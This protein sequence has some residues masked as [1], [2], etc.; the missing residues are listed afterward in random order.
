MTFSIV[1]WDALTGMTGVAVATKHLA[2]G[3]LVPHARAGVGAIATHYSDIITDKF[4]GYR[5]RNS[6]LTS[7]L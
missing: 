6:T 5:S 2:V 4:G 3:A 1:A 7:K